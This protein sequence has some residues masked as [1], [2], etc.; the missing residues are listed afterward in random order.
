MIAT[1]DAFA[2]CGLLERMATSGGYI[3]SLHIRYLFSVCYHWLLSLLLQ[4]FRSYLTG[5]FFRRSL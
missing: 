5:L 1:A 4:A 3:R 2:S